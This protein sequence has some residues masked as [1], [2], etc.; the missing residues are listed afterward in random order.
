MRTFSFAFRNLSAKFRIFFV[1][2]NEAKN[3]KTKSEISRKKFRENIF[4][5]VSHFAKSID[6]EAVFFLFWWIFAKRFS[7]SLQTDGNLICNIWAF[8]YCNYMQNS[9][10]ST[11]FWDNKLRSIS[12]IC[13]VLSTVYPWESWECLNRTLSIIKISRLYLARKDGTKDNSKTGENTLF[14]RFEETC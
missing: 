2:M 8:L 5:K 14:Y 3:E 13:F 7:F 6:V 11:N 12:W 1:K 10:V 4:A 9:G